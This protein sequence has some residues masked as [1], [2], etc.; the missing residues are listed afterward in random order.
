MF[1]GD[2][3][4]EFQ[5]GMDQHGLRRGREQDRLSLRRKKREEQLQRKRRQ[6]MAS[7]TSISNGQ[8]SSD[9]N[10]NSSNS[11]LA[12]TA[13]IKVSTITV[14]NLNKYILELKSSNA[15][16][17]ISGTMCIRILLSKADNPPPY[18]QIVDSGIVPILLSFFKRNNNEKLQ[19]EAAWAV[20][21]LLSSTKEICEYL[22]SNNAI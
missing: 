1:G 12:S 17:C 21:N 7:A 14:S 2:K 11:P 20:T 10:I 5:Q 9:I 3:T 19:F 22:C 13:G 15:S 8:Y 6:I 4:R 18:K 16:E